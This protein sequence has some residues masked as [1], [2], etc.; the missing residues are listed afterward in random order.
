M[1][2]MI[3]SINVF[4]VYFNRLVDSGKIIKWLYNE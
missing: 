1:M 4:N 2:G 3:L